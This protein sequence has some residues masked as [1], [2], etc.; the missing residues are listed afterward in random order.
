MS[1]K[2]AIVQSL[3][4]L[5]KLHRFL[6]LSIAIF[7]LIS[8]VTGILLAL[9]KDVALLQPPTQKSSAPFDSNWLS[10]EEISTA[11][12]QAFYLKYPDQ[13]NNP[14]DK[15]DIRIS[16]GIGKVIFQNGN[17]EVQVD[18]KN[19]AILS[20]AKRH[21]DWIE[22]LH[23]GS[24]IS[25]WFKLISMNYLGFGAILLIVSGIWLWWGPKKIRFSRR[26]REKDHQ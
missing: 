21:S 14:V 13:S 11:A 25:D 17:W 22:S 10:I 24:I 18:G 6:G 5:R 7:L 3:R 15:I 4:S 19:G 2:N 8:A 16:K 26:R 23:D 20:M 12:T 9:K 1:I